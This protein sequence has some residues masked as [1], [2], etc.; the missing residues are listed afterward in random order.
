MPTLFEF[1][2]SEVRRIAA[3]DGALQILFAAAF[4]RVGTASSGYAQSLEMQFLDAR[5]D[6]ILADCIGRLSDGRLLA[7]ASA[8]SSIP[9]PYASAGPVQVELQ[10]SNGARL[11]IRAASLLCRFTGD[12][13][14]VESFAC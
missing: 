5:W 8:Q 4:V 2:D 14:F 13:Q 12:P 9:L 1:H 7:G 10:F 11:Q 3:Q 6:G